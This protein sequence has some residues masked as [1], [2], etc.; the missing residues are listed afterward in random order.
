MAKSQQRSGNKDADKK[1]PVKSLMEKRK[2][3]HDKQAAS[4]SR[5]W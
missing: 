3:K 1:K 4:K 2:D 5:G